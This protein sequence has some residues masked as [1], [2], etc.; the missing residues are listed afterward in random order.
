MF[1]EQELDEARGTEI[2]YMTAGNHLCEVQGYEAITSVKSGPAVVFT[3]KVVESDTLP[4]G[5]LAKVFIAR[6]SK[7]GYDNLAQIKRALC[8]IHGAKNAA[9]QIVD[10]SGAELKAF[11]EPGGDVFHQGSPVRVVGTDKMNKAGTGT[12]CVIEFEAA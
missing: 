1:N 3:F 6:R 7:Q 2:P 8:C 10:P 9:G 4:E 5:H 11:L 12:Y